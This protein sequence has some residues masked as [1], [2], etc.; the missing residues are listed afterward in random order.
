MNTR[1]LIFSPAYADYGLGCFEPIRNSGTP[2]QV[3][4]LDISDGAEV[5]I[6]EYKNKN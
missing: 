2:T 6:K 3:Y 1:Y 4:L 5:Y